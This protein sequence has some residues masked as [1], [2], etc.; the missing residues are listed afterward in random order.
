MKTLK[1]LASL[2]I[3][4]SAAA[5]GSIATIK[6]IPTWYAALEKP[7]FNP[8]NWVFGPVWTALYTLIGVSLYLVWIKETKQPKKRAY[9]FFGIQIVLNALWSIVFFGLHQTWGGLIV[10][11]TLVASTVYT[12]KLFSALSKASSKL[13]IP[14]VLWISFATCLNLGIALLN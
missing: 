6:N 3:S 4:F 14:Y 5:I 10:I 1:L 2:V 13:L 8:P 9:V 12:L 7:F 11:V